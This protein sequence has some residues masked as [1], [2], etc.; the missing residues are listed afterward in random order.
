MKRVYIL[1]YAHG[2]CKD[3]EPSQNRWSTDA[4]FDTGFAESTAFDKN[5]YKYAILGCKT[6]VDK[7]MNGVFLTVNFML[8]VSD[9]SGVACS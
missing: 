1:I 7:I 9:F 4:D 8:H 5:L 3:R 6:N 2:F